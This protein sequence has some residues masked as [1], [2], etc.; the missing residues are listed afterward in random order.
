MYVSIWVYISS[1]GPSYLWIL[2]CVSSLYLL[3]CFDIEEYVAGRFGQD[4]SAGYAVFYLDKSY[5]ENITLSLF[6]WTCRPSGLF[7]ALGN[8]TQNLRVCLECGRLARLSPSSSKL[9]ANFVLSNGKVHFIS[10]KIKLDKTEL[11]QSSQT[12]GLISAPTGTWKIQR[13]NV[14][15]IGGLPDRQKTDIYGGFFKGCIQDI[16]VNNQNLEFF[17]NSTSNASHN[18]ILVNVTQGCPGDDMCEVGLLIP[19]VFRVD[20]RDLF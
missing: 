7:P 6:V 18:P 8:S 12:L 1:S 17:P 16:R 5:G 4:D 2:R 10:L 13:G 15:Y 11:H 9:E 14:L 3:F 20:G 19:A